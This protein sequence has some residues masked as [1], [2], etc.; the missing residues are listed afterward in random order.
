MGKGAMAMKGQRVKRS[1]EHWFVW[2]VVGLIVGQIIGFNVPESYALFVGLGTAF[3]SLPLAGV[4]DALEAR[5][6]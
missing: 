4:I 3:G 5:H 1:R 6:K 2:F